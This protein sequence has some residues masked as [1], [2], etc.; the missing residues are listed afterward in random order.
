MFHSNE[1]FLFLT[2]SFVF[3][4]FEMSL[5]C[6]YLDSNVSKIACNTLENGYLTWLFGKNEEAKRVDY[7]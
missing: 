7:K 6:Q 2:L 5:K 1:Q 4:S 3:S